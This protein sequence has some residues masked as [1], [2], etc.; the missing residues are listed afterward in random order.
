MAAPTSD[1]IPR[2]A[3]AF[4][5]TAPSCDNSLKILAD[6]T[7]DLAA[8]VGLFA[9]D[10]VERYTIDYTRGFLPPV[11]AP[12]SLLGILGYVRAL[13]KL[14]LGVQFCER[15]GFSTISLRS[16]A[17]VRKSEVLVN[18]RLTKV[19]YLQ[20]RN[21][22]GYIR[23]DIVKNVE[24]TKESMPLTIGAGQ[25]A[26]KD[27]R[28]FDR[29]YSVAMYTL[30]R[31]RKTSYIAFGMCAVGLASA[32]SIA[33]CPILIFST[34]RTWTHIFASAGLVISILIGGLPWCWIYLQEH[35]PFESCQWF[36]S[37]WIDGTPTRTNSFTTT[38][39]CVSRK[40]TFAFFAKDSH[41]YIFDCCAQRPWQLLIARISSCCAAMCITVAY[42]CQYVELHS[43]SAR[44]SEIWLGVQGLLA[45][46]RIFAWN[47]AP[48]VLGFAS[49]TVIRS[50]D[51]RNNCFRDSLTEL[52]LI[53]CWA[54]IE[55][56]Q[57]INSED[58]KPEN[59]ICSSSPLLPEWL[60][61]AID[62][63]R[64]SEAL[65]L[66][67]QLQRGSDPANHL[68]AIQGCNYWDM[69]ESIFIRW[70]KLRCGDHGRTI[71]HTA[72]QPQGSWECR[73]I[74]DQFGVL[75]ILPGISIWVH[76]QG[77]TKPATKIF[78]F[79]HEESLDK[80]AFYIPE[81]GTHQH[82]YYGIANI[83]NDERGWPDLA[84]Q[85][86]TPRY[87]PRIDEL[88]TELTSA[89]EVLGLSSRK[90]V[91]GPSPSIGGSSSLSLSDQKES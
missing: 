44:G 3:P 87:R 21:L 30:A 55:N 79:N 22:N 71:R 37:D 46:L 20:R 50:I 25:R 10:G 23:W 34:Y 90:G 57:T 59:E 60:T 78:L 74:L 32:A 88:W 28:A 52:E 6:G 84:R 91:P 19:K 69:P 5:T 66:S 1:T 18:E 36:R 9:T 45:I 73:I 12:L 82:W 2:N 76:H 80:T 41:F 62:D 4:Q 89:L 81:V 56:K 47:W 72:A 11:T 40:D 16:Y 68:M 77:R 61:K 27:R 38:G 53:L 58:E 65:Q 48:S 70:L 29:S 67:H 64:L 85:T 17:G 86:L 14:S 31:T 83:P 26:P 13:L 39:H 51:Q 35:L 49:D 54:S 75:H 15:I 42:I 24:H 33:S 63:L 8:L 43:A 7:Q